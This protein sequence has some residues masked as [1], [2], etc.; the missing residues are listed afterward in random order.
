MRLLQ[1]GSFAEV[2]RVRMDPTLAQEIE[3]HLRAY[4][5]HVLERDVRSATVRAQGEVRVLTVDKRNFL[6]RIHEDPSLA[7][8]LVET[9]SGRIRDLSKEVTQYKESAGQIEA[10]DPCEE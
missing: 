6:R 9:M 2:S 3:M 10:P 7:F 4:L 5:I 1:S 8:R